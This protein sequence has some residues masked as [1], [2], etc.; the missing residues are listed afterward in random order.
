MC[1]RGQEKQRQRSL[2]AFP[3][4]AIRCH[5]RYKRPNPKKQDAMELN[6]QIST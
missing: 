1:Y 4:D 3:A 2:S 5:E 6:K